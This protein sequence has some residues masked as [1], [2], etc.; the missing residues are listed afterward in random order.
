MGEITRATP[1]A[2]LPEILR[3]EEAAVWLD[4][5]KGVLYEAV[6]SGELPGIR[7]GRL[8]RISREGL[9]KFVADG[10]R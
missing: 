10:T 4:C 8:L 2:E 7:L 1:L 9:A 5:S 6:K 3:V